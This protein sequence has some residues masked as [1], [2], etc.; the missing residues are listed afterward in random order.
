MRL[1]FTIAL[2]IITIS[3]LKFNTVNA[4]VNTQ[5][6]LA[7]VDLYHSTGGS[8]YYWINHTNWLTVSPVS[9]WYG[10]SVTENRVTQISLSNNGLTGGIPSSIEN[11]SELDSLNL[12]Y[13]SFFDDTIPDELWNLTNLTSLNLSYCNMT[14]IHLS[15]AV[16]N[17]TKLTNLNLSGNGFRSGIPP[18]IGNLTKLTNL[19]LELSEFTGEIPSTIGNL[20][21]LTNLDLDN[22]QL[23]GS[24]PSEIGNLTKL[25]TLTLDDN[26]LSG[27]LPSTIG[28]L[29]NL[30]TA[31]LGVNQLTGNLPSTMGNLNKLEVIDLSYNQLTGSIPTA[32]GNLSN[33]TELWLND[34]K[35]TG[36]IPSTFGD[37]ATLKIFYLSN[38]QLTGSIPTTLGN[39]SNL[40]YV[41]L[42][43]NKLSGP[44]PSGLSNI[45]NINLDISYNQYTFT[46]PESLVNPTGQFT[47]A[48]QA[49][50]KLHKNNNILSVSA[51]GTLSNNTYS[52]YKDSKFLK[53]VKG[54]STLTISDPGK[55]WVAVTNSIATKL[56]LHSD[57]F[58][59]NNVLP[60]TLLF[61]TAT[62]Q[63][64]KALLQWS[65]AQ[66]ID[67]S[68]F[69]IERSTGNINF[70]S[71]GRINAA[72]NLIKNNYSFTDDL[73]KESSPSSNIFYRLKMVN[74]D[75][76]FSYSEIRN[77]KLNDDLFIKLY[78]NPA[79]SNTTISVN[80]TGKYSI[81]ITDVSGKILQIKTGINLGRVNTIQ[82]DVSKYSKGIYFITIKNAMNN[83]QTIKLHKE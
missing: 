10:I 82:L 43:N 49:N 23:T 6:S 30:K 35:L 15:P 8:N 26:H 45:V 65:T 31:Y 32:L 79:R 78:P 9:T 47:Y 75:G 27:S 62:E 20:T 36:T 34:N 41:S 54:D 48:P 38:N 2:F 42:N 16:G 13:S 33:I 44:I 19:E 69:D 72:N 68:Y 7:L 24:I 77:I 74:K 40:A 76:T 60:L 64:N 29:I 83:S 11:L 67:M 55:Y 12:S 71:I 51:G 81:T 56:T 17:L 46:G 25:I 70:T 4:Q 18:E 14:Y 80:A 52:W 28:N 59:T 39:L 73:S 61:F 5:D 57:T 21:E 50:I 58:D 66:E 37:L 63:N 3:S 1:K 22:N 53:A